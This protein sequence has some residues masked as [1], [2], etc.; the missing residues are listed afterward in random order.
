MPLLAR[1]KRAIRDAVQIMKNSKAVVSTTAEK[2]PLSMRHFARF[3]ANLTLGTMLALL[4]GVA[5]LRDNPVGTVIFVLS[6]LIVFVIW[7][8]TL[9]IG[10]L[11]TTIPAGGWRLNKRP[12]GPK[13]GDV[14][15]PGRVWD[16]W[17]DGP[18]PL[19]P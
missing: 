16:R 5:V 10:C 1:L 18:E 19:R 3:A 2:R 7:S 8:V 11:T 14:A 12:S 4:V 6:P 9:A 13:S 17:M 15:P